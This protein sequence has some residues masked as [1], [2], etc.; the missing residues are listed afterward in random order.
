M[1]ADRGDNRVVDFVNW[2]AIDDT[3]ALGQL[4]GHVV[5]LAGQLLGAGSV[6]DGSF[7]SF[8]APAFSPALPNSDAV[9]ILAVDG[10]M[11][12]LVFGAPVMDPVFYFA[13]F[14]SIL[15]FLDATTV[16]MLSGDE[17]F[18]VSGATVTGAV[19]REGFRPAR[20]SPDAKPHPYHLKAVN[21]DGH[22]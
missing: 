13:S 16:Q 15:S 7:P 22:S 21:T 12:T 11:F 8:N 1:T 6:V 10:N 9:N 18:T 14:V 5:T 20:V 4:H 17:H 19:R 3:F 2:M